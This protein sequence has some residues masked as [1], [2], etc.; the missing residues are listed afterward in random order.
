MALPLLF[1]YMAYAPRILLAAFEPYTKYSGG[2]LSLLPLFRRRE[3][4]IFPY[5]LLRDLRRTLRPI[6][7][8]FRPLRPNIACSVPTDLS[9]LSLAM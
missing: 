5:I 9:P 3:D 7:T 8:C 4:F 1:V 2:S 6:W